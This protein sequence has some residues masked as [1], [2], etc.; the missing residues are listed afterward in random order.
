MLSVYKG[1]TL[2]SAGDIGARPACLQLLP[3]PPMLTP[4]PDLAT[5]TGEH[6]DSPPK[7]LR[8]LA[9]NYSELR[10]AG[11]KDKAKTHMEMWAAMKNYRTWV[12]VSQP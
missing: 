2:C 10:Q 8:C 5:C 11:K 12:M 4:H 6:L 7:R 1:G 3:P 9:G